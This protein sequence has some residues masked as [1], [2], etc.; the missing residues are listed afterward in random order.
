MAIILPLSATMAMSETYPHLTKFK[1][2]GRLVSV[3]ILSSVLGQAVV[4]IAF[5]LFAFHLLTL[6]SWYTPYTLGFEN[7][8]ACQE[9]STLYLVSIY[10]YVIVALAFM[11]GKPFRKSFYTNI[12]FTLSLAALLGINL[13]VTYNPF[14][15]SFLTD[16]TLD[17]EVVFLLSWKN[18][19]VI[20]AVVNG[21]VTLLWERLIVKTVS[22]SWK[23]HRDNKE[24]AK[25]ELESSFADYSAVVPQDQTKY[26]DRSVMSTMEAPL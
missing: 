2:T 24:Q 17:A 22:L 7:Q 12:Y 14:N 25:A 21:F 26:S 3:Q 20:I 11:V 19:I 4:Q 15:F 18:T 1:P 9:N 5:Q 16:G 6:Q 13:I 10:Q 8:P 23:S